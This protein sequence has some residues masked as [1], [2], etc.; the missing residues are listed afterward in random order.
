MDFHECSIFC[1]GE[2]GTGMVTNPFKKF[3]CHMSLRFEALSHTYYNQAVRCCCCFCFV[4]FFFF[5]F[6]WFF[7]CLLWNMRGVLLQHMCNTVYLAAV[8]AALLVSY[9]SCCCAT[10]RMLTILSG[11]SLYAVHCILPFKSVCLSVCLSLSLSLVWQQV[12]MS[13]LPSR[14]TSLST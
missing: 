1:A 3:T 12:T 8:A 4:F 10:V 6:L 13:C 14:V 11:S 7:C 9:A 5:F 2:L